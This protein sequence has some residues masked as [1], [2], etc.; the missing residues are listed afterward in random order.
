MLLLGKKDNT[1]QKTKRNKDKTDNKTKL[2][3]CDIH[4]QTKGFSRASANS[5]TLLL[6]LVVLLSVLA[7]FLLS[8]AIM[9]K[10]K[11]SF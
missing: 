10:F 11:V 8:A 4:S 7:D 1:P 6:F 9:F 2:Y 3:S 5:Y